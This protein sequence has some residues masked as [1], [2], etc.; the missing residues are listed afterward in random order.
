MLFTDT[1]GCTAGDSH[2]PYGGTCIMGNQAIP[3]KVHK[4]GGSL[5]VLLVKQIR[6]ALPWRA[7]DMVGLRVCGEKLMIER[8]ALEKVAI[9]RTGEAQERTGEPF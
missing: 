5:C 3:A 6:D 1:T 4:Y 2:T 8:I 9:I 7:G